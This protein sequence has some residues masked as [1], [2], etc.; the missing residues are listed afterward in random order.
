[1]GRMTSAL[2]PTADRYNSLKP[3]ERY[4]FRR[5]CRNLVKWY[6]YLSQV[7]R[8]FDADLHKEYLFVR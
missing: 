7:V 3:D 2:M 4:Q 1:M 6:G 5:L 8:M